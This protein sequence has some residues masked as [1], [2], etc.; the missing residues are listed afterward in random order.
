MNIAKRYI[1]NINLAVMG[2]V[3][4]VIRSLELIAAAAPPPHAPHTMSPAAR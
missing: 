3:W 2:E 1:K 4:G